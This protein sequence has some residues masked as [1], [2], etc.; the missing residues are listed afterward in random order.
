M[1]TC[2]RKRKKK[3]STKNGKNNNNASG[4][5]L[6]AT[7]EN[8]SSLFCTLGGGNG[9]GNGNDYDYDYDCNNNDETTTTDTKYSRYGP[10]A[11]TEF[12]T[13]EPLKRKNRKGQRQRRAKAQAMEAKKHGR[14][15]LLHQR[16]SSNWR[17]PKAREYNDDDDCNNGGGAG[18]DHN[19]TGRSGSRGRGKETSRNQRPYNNDH[20]RESSSTKPEHPKQD[21]EVR[22]PSWAAKQAQST[23]IV[24]FQ[25]KKITFD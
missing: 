20:N 2:T 12:T 24:A 13:A 1:A 9:N 23:G 14:F 15:R 22:H 6:Q 19:T 8:E 18:A 11:S 21:A 4:D 10:A 3:T 5:G 16:Q 25:G 17:E 7:V